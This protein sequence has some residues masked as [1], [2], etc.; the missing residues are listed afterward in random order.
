M[1][2]EGAG[3]VGQAF[4]P[5]TAEDLRRLKLDSDVLFADDTQGLGPADVE[6]RR[7]RRRAWVRRALGAAKRGFVE[8]HDARWLCGTWNCAG[9][10]YGGPADG[11][12]AWLA[13]DPASPPDVVC[14][15]LQEM[16]PLSARNVMLHRG[17]DAVDAWAAR[18]LG[19]LATVDA[20]GGVAQGKGSKGGFV[21]VAR[22]Q[23]V[24]VG[25]VVA[26]REAVAAGMR[27]PAQVVTRGVGLLG[28]AANKGV[29]CAS[30]ALWDTRVAVVAA[31]LSSGDEAAAKRH[32]EFNDVSE[33]VVFPVTTSDDVN[34]LD[35]GV[36]EARAALRDDLG[37][38]LPAGRLGAHDVVFWMGD[39]NYRFGHEGAGADGAR[40]RRLV[41]SEDWEALMALDQ[42]RHAQAAGRAFSS[43]QEMAPC[44]MPS[45]KWVPGEDRY[46]AGDGARC[47]AWTDRVLW[48]ASL[49]DADGDPCVQPLAYAACSGAQGL[50]MSDHR[51]VSA[52]FSVRLLEVDR[53][54]ARAAHA[55]VMR[56]LDAAEN[57]ARPKVGVS[58]LEVLAEEDV[59]LAYGS[60]MRAMLC[61]RDESVAGTGAVF[62]LAPVGEG[63]DAGWLRLSPRY[64]LVPAGGSLEVAVEVGVDDSSVALRALAT[65]AGPSIEAQA[66]WL[67]DAR[68]VPLDAFVV[69]HA[70]GGGDSFV[71]VRAAYRPGFRAL[72]LALLA[73]RGGQWSRTAALRGRGAG[74]SREE[75]WACGLDVFPELMRILAALAASTRGPD[76]AT[77]EA[78][79]FL[80]RPEDIRAGEGV[81]DG[82]E[83]EVGDVPPGSSPRALVALLLDT[84][85]DLPDP[86]LPNEALVRMG[87]AL[88][89]AQ[90]AEA[91][92]H[93]GGVVESHAQALAFSNNL[94]RT[95]DAEADAVAAEVCGPLFRC[96]VIHALCPALRGGPALDPAR[97][98]AAEALA[99]AMQAPS[100]AALRGPVSDAQRTGPAVRLVASLLRPRR[101]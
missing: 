31:H 79:W 55:G 42:L 95:L 76:P 12:L 21:V 87:A 50:C 69:V 57:L 20:R 98:Y 51:P 11:L 15:A 8:A 68:P 63:A 66:A 37:D 88:A 67:R 47:P 43:Y 96:V 86:L 52:V 3:E 13:P 9:R 89:R 39:L 25:L 83:G 30:F 35:A 7:G 23:L 65:A 26:A 36:A 28:V 24:G 2:T 80:P 1:G 53:A 34:G 75:D 93:G 101:R 60:S 77:P 58:P 59:P 92:E 70:V 62:S 38:V 84:L 40:V 56:Q 29:V 4:L 78:S 73:A 71:Q 64:G 17:S 49:C 19:A 74:M 72:P 14:V 90:Q 44:F 99:L 5:R 46:E 32:A 41:E 81:A 33:R 97:A 82:I 61:L 91:A 22:G 94:A 45:Y 48:R 85:A 10:A 16:V 100:R 54:C 27:G 6:R 18:I